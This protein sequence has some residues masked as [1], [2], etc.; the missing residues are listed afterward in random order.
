MFK[1]FA[2][3]VS[4]FVSDHRDDLACA[5]MC[6]IFVGGA[7]TLYFSGYDQ[8]YK[9]RKLLEK[10]AGNGLFEAVESFGKEFI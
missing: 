9:T 4:E 6:V 7:L 3:N 2:N 8:G 1:K 10:A 5:A